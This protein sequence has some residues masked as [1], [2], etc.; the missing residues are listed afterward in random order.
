[1]KYILI[2]DIVK[3]KPTLPLQAHHIDLD[4]YDKFY[5]PDAYLKTH[6]SHMERWHADV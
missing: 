6:A 4:F 5:K 2:I 3:S 1:L